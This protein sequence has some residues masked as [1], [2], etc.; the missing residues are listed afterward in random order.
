MSY[1]N[2]ISPLMWSIKMLS[3]DERLQLI[4]TDPERCHEIN[5]LSDL[6]E[7]RDES[8]VICG[9]IRCFKNEL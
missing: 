9:N 7:L 2:N 4:R 3:D 8:S 5:L 1:V 6:G